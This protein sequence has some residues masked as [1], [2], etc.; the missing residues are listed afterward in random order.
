M[1]IW[2]YF[3]SLKENMIWKILNVTYYEVNCLNLYIFIVINLH[4]FFYLTFFFQFFEVNKDYIVEDFL[5]NFD[6]STN[7]KLEHEKEYMT[8]FVIPNIL[9]GALIIFFD[10]LFIILLVIIWKKM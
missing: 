7:V 8:T 1:M 2:T 10:I 6:N 4:L 5:K 3:Q 9:A